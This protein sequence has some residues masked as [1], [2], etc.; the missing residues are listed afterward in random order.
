[1]KSQITGGIRFQCIVEKGGMSHN[2][3]KK[4]LSKLGE[5]KK[6]K[7]KSHTNGR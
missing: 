1:M 3:K 7:N 2:L 5:K 6:N 4:H